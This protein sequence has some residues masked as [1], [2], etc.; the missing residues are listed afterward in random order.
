ME[1][2]KQIFRKKRC[3]FEKVETST[4]PSFGELS[5]SLSSRHPQ[6]LQTRDND[7]STRNSSDMLS[8]YK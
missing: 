8:S 6:Y 7:N 2:S 5:R 1:S 3:A 4:C